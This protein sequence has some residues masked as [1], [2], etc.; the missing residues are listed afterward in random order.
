MRVNLGHPWSRDIERA[1]RVLDEPVVQPSVRKAGRIA[2]RVCCAGCITAM[3]PIG[4]RVTLQ[5]P[6]PFPDCP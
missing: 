5:L 4:A 2:R 6:P 3:Q 1:I